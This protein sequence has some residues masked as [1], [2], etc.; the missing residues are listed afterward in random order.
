MAHGHFGCPRSPCCWRGD[1]ARP[2]GSHK[3][4]P[5]GLLQRR[6]LERGDFSCCP[7]C[8][9]SVPARRGFLLCL[10][11]AVSP[12][13][14]AFPPSCLIFELFIRSPGAQWRSVGGWRPRG[15][16]VLAPGLR[17][18]VPRGCVGGS[19]GV[20]AVRWGPGLAVPWLCCN[21]GPSPC[22]G[23]PNER[24]T[25]PG[26]RR[27]VTS[28]AS[29]R[30][31]L[32]V[33]QPFGGMRFHRFLFVRGALGQGCVWGA[34]SLLSPL[35][36]DTALLF[37]AALLALRWP[38]LGPAPERPL[39]LR[40][41]AFEPAGEVSVVPQALLPGG[42]STP[43]ETAAN[44]MGPRETSLSCLPV[45]LPNCLRGLWGSLLSFWGIPDVAWAGGGSR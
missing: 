21:L 30:L 13:L 39:C 10:Y 45:R 4:F 1:R 36:G 8:R 16:A 11:I 31:K 7:L 35:G 33:Y 44:I 27:S 26:G 37:P 22:A 41:G 29:S 19:G 2:H 5:A 24:A 43:A 34:P 6:C 17:L 32:G 14:A 23:C 28:S 38:R 12:S 9:G 20:Q 15:E 40:Q 25:V 42:T 18:G 3:P